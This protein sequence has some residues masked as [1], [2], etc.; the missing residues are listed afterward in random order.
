MKNDTKISCGLILW[1]PAF[2]LGI[3]SGLVTYGFMSGFE[4]YKEMDI[5]FDNSECLSKNV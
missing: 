4:I 2:L 5:W 3:I 1:L